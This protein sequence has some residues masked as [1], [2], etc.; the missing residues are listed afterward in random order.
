MGP[1]RAGIAG[2]KDGAARAE[3]ERAGGIDDIPCLAARRIRR[4]RSGKLRRIDRFERHS[5]S[6]SR[7]SIWP[8][9]PQKSATL[10]TQPKNFSTLYRLASRTKSG[11]RWW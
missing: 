1:L 8:N 7:F 2:M 11:P 5:Y 3:G 4:D 6:P 9:D 10:D